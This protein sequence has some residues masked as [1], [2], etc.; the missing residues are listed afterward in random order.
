MLSHSQPS[1]CNGTGDIQSYFQVILGINITLT[2]LDLEPLPE[3][4]KSNDM[5]DLQQQQQ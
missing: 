4:K 5:K 1:P 2:N 3:I